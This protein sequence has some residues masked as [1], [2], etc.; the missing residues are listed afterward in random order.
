MTKDHLPKARYKEL[1]SCP[2]IA[3]HQPR[4]SHKI[5]V[6]QAVILRGGCQPPLSPRLQFLVVVRLP[7]REVRPL[8]WQVVEG[9]NRHKWVQKYPARVAEF[10]Y[11]TQYDYQGVEAQS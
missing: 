2:K 10:F 1:P 6:G 8:V 3:S 7:L 5:D 9:E 11:D 4:I